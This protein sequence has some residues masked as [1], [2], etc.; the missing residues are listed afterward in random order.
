MAAKKRISMVAPITVL[1]D[2]E[3][4]GDLSDILLRS[5]TLP[6]HAKIDAAHIAIAAIHGM[7]YLLTLNCRHINNAVMKPKMRDVCHKAGYTCPEIC[8]PAELRNWRKP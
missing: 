8:S 2:S 4:A 7:D 3:E 5:L 1:P 6:S